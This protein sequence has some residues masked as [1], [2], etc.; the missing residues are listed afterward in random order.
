MEPIQLPVDINDKQYIDVIIT[1]IDGTSEITMQRHR[2]ILAWQSYFN[3][4]FSFGDNF[5]IHDDESIAIILIKLFY[6]V[7]ELSLVELLKITKSK[8]YLCIDIVLS[9]LYDLEI[10]PEYFDLL[11]EVINLPEIK[12]DS[13]LGTIKMNLPKDYDMSRLDVEETLKLWDLNTNRCHET[14]TIHGK[15]GCGNM[16]ISLDIY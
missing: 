12:I 16:N 9:K 2:N 14:S 10:S 5:T 7:I 1:F 3:T 4:F 8:L 15:M 11:L 13:K 6:Q